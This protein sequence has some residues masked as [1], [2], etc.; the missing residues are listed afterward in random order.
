MSP[1]CH[2]RLLRLADEQ[3]EDPEPMKSRRRT[4]ISVGHGGERRRAA[5]IDAP[6]WHSI[7]RLPRALGVPRDGEF[8]LRKLRRVVCSLL[9]L[10]LSPIFRPVHQ[11]R[12]NHR[13]D[14]RASAG[15]PLYRRR[16]PPRNNSSGRTAGYDNS[17]APFNGILL[18]LGMKMQCLHGPSIDVPISVPETFAT[19][20][21]LPRRRFV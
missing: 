10:R 6:A 1:G 17:A 21:F 13:D 18:G 2:R 14:G 11:S 3:E 20:R 16:T 8:T 7:R 4:S 5:L 9:R 19:R 15:S 12:R